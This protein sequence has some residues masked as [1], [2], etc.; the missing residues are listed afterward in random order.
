MHAVMLEL[1]NAGSEDTWTE[2]YTCDGD[3]QEWAEAL[4]AGFNATC[5]PGEKH[6][7]LVAVRVLGSAAVVEHDWQ[8]QNLV[9]I[10]GRVARF[11]T[12]FGAVGASLRAS[13]S[14]SV[15]ALSA[16]VSTA[17]RRTR[18]AGPERIAALPDGGAPR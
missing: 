14:H 5:R 6:R 13:G 16:T 2:E 12:P 10:Q 17:P 1:R 3:P 4:V 8:K 11:T 15:A 9:T 7:E 18:S